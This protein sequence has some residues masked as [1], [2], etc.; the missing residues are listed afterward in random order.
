H[1]R[2]NMLITAP[3]GRFTA[4]T[5]SLAPGHRAR[6]AFLPRVAA[7]LGWRYRCRRQVA[8]LD[9]VLAAEA[10]PVERRAR[11][12]LAPRGNVLVTADGPQGVAGAQGGQQALQR[13][14]LGVGIG[15]RVGA[16]QFDADREVV[17][18]LAVLG[19]RTTGVPSPLVGGHAM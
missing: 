1:R 4:S 12:G 7:T 19:N 5:G 10:L 2:S 13:S 11:V 8:A 17:A 6:S 3:G 9:A 16:F 14:V 15:Q 18:A